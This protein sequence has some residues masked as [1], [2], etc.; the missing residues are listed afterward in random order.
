MFSPPRDATI[1]ALLLLLLLVL[2][3]LLSSVRLVLEE[4]VEVEGEVVVVMGVVEEVVEEGRRV[5][6]FRDRT[7]DFGATNTRL[8]LFSCN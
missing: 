4:G 3:A 8:L 1:A 7:G 6:G 2:R 5:R